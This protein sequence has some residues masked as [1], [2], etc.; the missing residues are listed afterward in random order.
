MS[1]LQDS[2]FVLRLARLH[3]W[4]S[5]GLRSE[6]Q[7]GSSR[8]NIR[9]LL[10]VIALMRFGPNHCVEPRVNNAPRRSGPLPWRTEA[11]H[12]PGGPALT[13]QSPRDRA[14][15]HLVPVRAAENGFGGFGPR[16]GGCLGRAVPAVG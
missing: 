14:A 11:Q 13:R 9:K 3:E 5:P 8:R 7:R 1:V 12:R 4:R 6:D 16:R 15:A 10:E 2:V